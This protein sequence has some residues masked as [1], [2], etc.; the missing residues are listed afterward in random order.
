MSLMNLFAGV[1]IGVLLV[2]SVLTARDG[3]FLLAMG[4]LAGLLAVW[5]WR[6]KRVFSVIDY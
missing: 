5:V 1:L 3:Q 2:M 4:L 6:T